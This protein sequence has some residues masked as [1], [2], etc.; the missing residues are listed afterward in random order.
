MHEIDAR[1]LLSPGVDFKQLRQRATTS[2]GLDVVTNFS[3]HE[4]VRII[5]P[6]SMQRN[7]TNQPQT[8]VSS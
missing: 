4:V 3:R 8:A 7:T 6:L 2:E 1:V 5:G